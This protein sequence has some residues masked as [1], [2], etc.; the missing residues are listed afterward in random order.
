M[1]P[2]GHKLRREKSERERERCKASL[3]QCPYKLT[4]YTYKCVPAFYFE[5]IGGTSASLG[6]VIMMMPP[7]QGWTHEFNGVASIQ[8]PLRILV[9]P[10]SLSGAIHSGVIF[11]FKDVVRFRESAGEE[12]FQECF[13]KTL[14]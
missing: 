6:I 7:P 9:N 12:M 14:F 3:S 8:R 1:P 10:L 5:R 11:F 2:R 13:S 4:V